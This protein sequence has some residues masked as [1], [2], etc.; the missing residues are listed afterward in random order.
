MCAESWA[1][2]GAVAN[3]SVVTAHENVRDLTDDDRNLRAGVAENRRDSGR[4][5]GD[6]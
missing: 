3:P 5:I 4:R 2:P 1:L 6:E